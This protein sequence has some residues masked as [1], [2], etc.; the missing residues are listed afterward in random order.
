MMAAATAAITAL[1]VTE[2]PARAAS[3]VLNP[4][5]P[6]A[7]VQAASLAYSGGRAYVSWAPGSGASST[8]YQVTTY[9][10]GANGTIPEGSQTAAGR[11]AVV[12][13]LQVG[14]AYRF[15]ISAINSAGSGPAA[16]TNQIS[17]V[18]LAVP[19]TPTNV[20]LTASSSDNEV[21][22]S[23]LPAQNAPA[24][25]TYNI[26]V[27][28]GSGSSLHQVGAVS[29]TSPCSAETLQATPGST[30]SVVVAAANPV[31]QSSVVWSNAVT[32]AQPCTLA[33]LTVSTAGASGVESHLANGLLVPNGPS[34]QAQPLTSLQPT[35]WRTNAATLASTG[36]AT[37]SALKGTTITDLLSDDWLAASG[38]GYAALPWSNWSAYSQWVTA[39]V[40]RVE[41]LGRQD[42]YT[43][44]YWDVQNEPFGGYYYSG[45]S[46]PPASET[47]ANFDQQFLTAYKAIK[48]ADPTA[49]VLGPSLIAWAADPADANGGIDMRSF[50]DF[51]AENGIQLG[52]VSFHDNDFGSLPGWYAA[53]G[54]PAQP[55]EVDAE[56][57]QLQ[58]ML[59]QR[60]SLG[61]PAMLVNEYGDPYS[62]EL[63]GWDVGRIAALQAAQV[64]G[65]NRSCWTS[66]SCGGASLDGLMTDDGTAPLPGYWVYNFYSTMTGRVAPVSSTYTD[67]TGLATVDTTGTVRVL[68]GRHQSCTTAVAGWCPIY[69]ALPASIKVQV[70]GAP[71][72]QVTVAAVPM[73]STTQSPLTSLSSTTVTEA[74][75]G[76][77]VTV[78]TP[79]MHDGDAVEIT[80]TPT[81]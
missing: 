79:A 21:T 43:V 6:P 57:A 15:A 17:A 74:A 20:R 41:A 70:P 13:G 67:V 80:V 49:R 64:T 66:S 51:C 29:C 50:L 23:W 77:W 27:Y 54:Q 35:N 18:G 55:S 11:D 59:A 12:S 81:V 45:S 48:A 69:S 2:S 73:G 62:S 30:T 39:Q 34:A 25:E 4:S 8:D 75:S 28:E 65:A 42:G 56:I 61:N 7:P 31:G 68:V 10:V 19:G 52:G 63:P 14:S 32:V 44:S 9:L 46:L 24:A 76:G 26:G 3:P 16:M 40:Q 53:D 33:C 71:A 47:V 72:A 38:G 37:L 60:P 5:L 1:T 22:V 58:Q 78:T 36:P